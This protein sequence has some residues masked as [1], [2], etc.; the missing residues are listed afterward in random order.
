MLSS[1]FFFFFAILVN[2]TRPYMA[3][4]PGILL[5]KENK[6]AIGWGPLQP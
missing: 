3:D 2:N 1:F 6:S 5:R 4:G